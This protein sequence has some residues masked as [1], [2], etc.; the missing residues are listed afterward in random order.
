MNSR[1][2]GKPL[3]RFLECYVLSCI[4]KLSEA[5]RRNLEMME[6]KL[7]AIY[8]IQG[9]WREITASVVGFD[10]RLDNNIRML[11]EENSKLAASHGED[12]LPEDFAVMVVDENFS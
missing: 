6:P 9:T 12:L 2:D 3:L 10:H 5:D 8:Q 11:W 1:Y 4:D 7:R